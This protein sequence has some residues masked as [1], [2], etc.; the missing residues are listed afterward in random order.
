MF[1]TSE[2]IDHDLLVEDYISRNFLELT[3]LNLE[4]EIA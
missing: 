1:L 3:K 4:F 2:G